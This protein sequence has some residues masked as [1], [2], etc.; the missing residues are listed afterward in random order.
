MYRSHTAKARS[1]DSIRNFVVDVIALSHRLT[2][3]CG[4]RF[5]QPL[6]NSLLSS[7]H[8]SFGNLTLAAGDVLCFNSTHSKSPL[9][10]NRSRREPA[11]TTDDSSVISSRIF[12]MDAHARQPR[13]HSRSE[14]SK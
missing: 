7:L 5:S 1:T 3:I 2:T 11:I 14:Q 12:E 10:K 13:E 9:G 6:G 8:L 4:A